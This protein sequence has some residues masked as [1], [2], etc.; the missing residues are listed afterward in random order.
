L[1]GRRQSAALLKRHLSGG[2]QL[3]SEKFFN[4]SQYDMCVGIYWREFLY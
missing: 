4:P 2:V 1:P 3:V